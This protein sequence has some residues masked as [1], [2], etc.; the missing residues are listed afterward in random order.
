[1]LSREALAR[2]RHDNFNRKLRLKVPSGERELS[3]EIDFRKVPA[4]VAFRSRGGQNVAL[5]FVGDRTGE[6]REDK[7]EAFSILV[8]GELVG[9]FRSAD[10]IEH[11]S[12]R[13]LLSEVLAGLEDEG[14]RLLDADARHSE[15]SL[16]RAKER[17]KDSLD[18][19]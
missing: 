1:M 2:L 15:G 13:S 7:R 9:R 6:G 8:N 19:L 18:R 12:L 14:R 5:V 4:R 11:Q 16:R 17:L 10:Q 3:L